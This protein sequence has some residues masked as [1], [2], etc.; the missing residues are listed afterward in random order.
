[1]P[2]A[3]S[4]TLAFVGIGLAAGLFSALLGVGGGVIVVSLLIVLCGFGTRSATGTSLAAI[5]LTAFFGAVA[6]GILGRV[7][8]GEAA[9]I[10]LP[11]VAGVLAGTWLQQRV[12]ARALVFAFAGFL[13]L[14]A[15]RLVVQ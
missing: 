2:A 15:V 1:V 3:R 9:L 7:H 8:W 13:V 5:G 14:I 4:A 12:S 6:Y 11:A 10:G